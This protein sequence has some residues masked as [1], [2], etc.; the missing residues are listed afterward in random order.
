MVHQRGLARQR[1]EDVPPRYECKIITKDGKER[2]LD[3]AASAILYEGIPAGLGIA[4]DVTD[5]KHIEEQ[6]QASELRYR[7]LFKA[8]PHPMWLYDI[9]TLQFLEVNDAAVHYYGYSREEFLSMS[10]KDI[11]PEKDVKDL[12]GHLQQTAEN[13]GFNEAGVWHHRKK[14][15]EIIDVEIISHTLEF[16]GHNAKLILATEI[17]K[18]K[19]TR[20]KKS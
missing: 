3:F 15:G 13:D 6:L 1:N 20:K 4:F 8:N 11:R 7:Q 5:R 9:D 14:N 17:T 12:I 19:R 10:I 2:W 16:N 18:Q